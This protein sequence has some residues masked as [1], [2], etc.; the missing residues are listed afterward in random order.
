MQNQFT[1][2]VTT[3]EFGTAVNRSGQ[4]IRKNFCLQGEAYGIRP[5]KIGGRLM[6]PADQIEKLLRGES[7][8][9]LAA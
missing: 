9:S 6:W 2:F 5:T 4:T 3:A 7:P 1:K 8:T